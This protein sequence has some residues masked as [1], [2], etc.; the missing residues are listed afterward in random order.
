[1]SQVLSPV[2]PCWCV[3]QVGFT[4]PNM[5]KKALTDISLHC[6]LSSRVAVLGVNGAG[7]STLIKLLTGELKS[8]DGTVSKHPN[9]RVAYVAQVR[10]HGPSTY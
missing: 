1:M 7:K 3:V 9:L 6:R 5:S 10:G 2:L 4:Y 8:N